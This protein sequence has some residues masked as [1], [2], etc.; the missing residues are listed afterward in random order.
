MNP[1]PVKTPVAIVCFAVILA[2]IGYLPAFEQFHA[3]RFET[4]GSVFDFELPT[5]RGE[6]AAT[7]AYGHLIDRSHAMDS[8]YHSLAR[9][10]AGEP[11]AI[12]RV[13]HFGDSP[14]SADQISA[15]LRTLLQNR[16]GNAGQGFVLIA[17]PWAWYNHRGIGMS[18]KGWT[19]EA[20]SQNYAPDGLHGLGGATFKGAVGAIANFELETAPQHMEL[21]YWAQPGGGSLEIS[22]RGEKVAQV[23]T[24]SLTRGSGFRRVPV[25]DA[26]R[27]M[28]LRVTSGHVRLFGVSFETDGPGV[29]Y[30]SLGLNAAQILTP[31]RHFDQRHWAEQIRHQKPDLVV[32]NYGTNESGYP[33]YIDGPYADDVRELVRRV[34][35]A[36]P[37]ASILM[38]SPM[39]RGARNAKGE[40]ATL[41]KLPKLVAIQRQVAAEMGCAFFNTFQ[42]MGGEGTMARWYEAR[43]R[44]A[45][46]DFM[47]PLPAGAKRLGIMMNEALYQGYVA[48][49]LRK[50]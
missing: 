13:L 39:D 22:A 11:G 50:R 24:D 33:G 25:P 38:M 1:W 45:S 40:I 15:D 48:Y 46:A 20:A 35:A 2:G 16:F 47:H 36:A 5:A 14:V 23:S 19:I 7:S 30:D 9:A 18:A 34:Q 43:P 8:F 42:A 4:L 44:L 49:Q 6:A 10:E 31:L 17:K 32:I 26:V 41:P 12:V 21:Q 28:Q 37:D 29:R 3:L 27:G